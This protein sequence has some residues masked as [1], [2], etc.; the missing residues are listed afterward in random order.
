MTYLPTANL[1]PLLT[2]TQYSSTVSALQTALIAAYPSLNIQVIADTVSGETSNAVV[3][4]NN[5]IVFTVPQNSYVGYN[6]G[7]WAQYT[8]A[9]FAT[10]FT[11]YP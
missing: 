2:F 9:K 3:I 10:L 8:S 6:N 1:S 11:T 4:S 5:S 7:A